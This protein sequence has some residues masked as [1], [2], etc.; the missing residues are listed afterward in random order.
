M[1]WNEVAVFTRVVD[2]G[3]FTKAAEQLGVPKSTVSRRVSR[4]EQALGVRLLQRTTRRLSLTDAGAAYYDRVSEAFVHLEEASAVVSDLQGAPRGLLR[5][6]APPDLG[7]LLGETLVEFR[8]SYPDIRVELSLTGRLVDL[9]GE[10]FDVAMRGGKLQDSSLV[11]KKLGE[12]SEIVVAAP[13]YLEGRRPPETPEDL[14]Q[15]AVVVFRGRD[16]HVEWTLQRADGARATVPLRGELGGDEYGFVRAATIA[17]AGVA[18]L[19]YFHASRALED[20]RLVRL[21]PGWEQRGASLHLVFP[22]GRHL[23]RK[24]QAFKDF[25]AERV[26]PRTVG[27]PVLPREMR[28]APKAAATG[29]TGATAA[30]KAREGTPEKAGRGKRKPR[31]DDARG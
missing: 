15:H 30:T 28:R 9:V 10:G 25:V 7:N 27:E 4:L 14:P 19:P 5:V 18:L 21:L 11:A 29:G 13:R 2:A 20:G 16:G 24:V 3:S 1:D 26:M 22:S 23:P 31:G 8:R 12:M 17:G 6:T